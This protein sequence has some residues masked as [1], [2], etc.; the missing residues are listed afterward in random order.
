VS[1]GI[2][3]VI[4]NESIRSPDSNEKL[5]KIGIT[6]KSVSDRY[7]G[8][9]L[10]MP[11]KFE[12]LFAYKLQNFSKAEQIIHGI[13][14]KYRENGEWFK[15]EEKELNHIKETCEIMGGILVTNDIYNE[16]ENPITY[17]TRHEKYLKCGYDRGYWE[18]KSSMENV[19]LADEIIK[20]IKEID[21]DYE[22]SFNQKQYIGLV[23]Y[24]NP[25]NFVKCVPMKDFFRIR[26]RH[27][28]NNEI[29]KIITENGLCFETYE[30]KE[31]RAG[32]ENRYRIKVT[33]QD[34]NNKREIL[35]LLFEKSYHENN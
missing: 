6:K 14:N 30:S 29:D 10:K 7:Y 19:L 2:L 20:I 8:L 22:L 23:K 18:N 32:K 27:T 26:F 16:E 3:Y 28:R 9:G 12:T 33:K 5:Y 17:S 24:G 21:C 31:D 15:L 13:L 25:N 34:I 35:K 1:A 11:G 4:Y